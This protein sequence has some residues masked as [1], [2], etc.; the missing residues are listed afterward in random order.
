M[1][2]VTVYTTPSCQQCRFTKRWLDKHGVDYDVV[3]LS[4][5]TQALDAVREMGY[6]SAPVVFA[7]PAPGVDVHWYG[8]NPE[9][10]AQHTTTQ[11]EAA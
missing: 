3:D 6:G 11:E 10:L 5:D 7:S 1:T 2:A 8:F 4:Q 9:K